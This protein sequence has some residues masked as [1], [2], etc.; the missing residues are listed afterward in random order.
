MKVETISFDSVAN[1]LSPRLAPAAAPLTAPGAMQG[2]EVFWA[3]HQDEVRA[4]QRLRYDVFA[5]EMGARLTTPIAG[6]GQRIRNLREPRRRFVL[7]SYSPR[8]ACE[9]GEGTTRAL[10]RFGRDGVR[11]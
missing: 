5:G 4:A 2:M 1:E 6:H 10:A 7:A 9:C 8:P 3:R 11:R